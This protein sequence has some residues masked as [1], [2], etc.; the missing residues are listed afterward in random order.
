MRRLFH[1]CWPTVAVVALTALLALQ[2]PRKALFFPTK[3][4]CCTG[5]TILSRHH[6]AET[7]AASTFDSPAPRFTSFVTS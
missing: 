4:L 3:P 5:V 1:A 2:I 6:P 7:S